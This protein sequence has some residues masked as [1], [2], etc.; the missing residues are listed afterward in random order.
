MAGHV[1]AGVQ[2]MLGIFHLKAELSMI[3]R[4]GELEG[5]QTGLPPEAGGQRSVLR[6]HFQIGSID[7]FERKLDEAQEDLGMDPA[8]F[9]PVT[10]SSELSLVSEFVKLLPTLLIIGGYIWFTRRS[11]GGLGGPGGPG[12]RGIFNVGKAQV[13]NVHSTVHVFFYVL[14]EHKGSGKGCGAVK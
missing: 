14:H 7:S 12:G 10:Y 4:P 3:C 6:Y 8:D 11:M 1:I 5:M 9:V 2:D 13:W